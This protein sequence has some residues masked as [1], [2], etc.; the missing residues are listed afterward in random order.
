MLIGSGTG[1][2]TEGAVLHNNFLRGIRVRAWVFQTQPETQRFPNFIHISGI[3][4][5]DTLQ[6]KG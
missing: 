5:T 3:K 4:V 2:D 6:N 1:P